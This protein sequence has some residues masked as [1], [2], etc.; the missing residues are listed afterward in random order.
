MV[1]MPGRIVNCLHYHFF[2]KKNKKLFSILYSRYKMPIL[3]TV[4]WNSF[5][6]G[7]SCLS[8]NSE[9]T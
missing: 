5:S 7:G 9:L 1:K 6:V 3:N 8:I 2:Y 4:I